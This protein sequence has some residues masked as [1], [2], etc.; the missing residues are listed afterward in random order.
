MHMQLGTVA[1]GAE[2]GVGQQ[3]ARRHQQER[4]VL[5]GMDPQREDTVSK[6]LV[7]KLWSL[8]RQKRR[9]AADVRKCHRCGGRAEP[10]KHGN[11]NPYR[12]VVSN[13]RL[14]VCKGCTKGFLAK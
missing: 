8:L 2:S 11:G 10:L 6:S 14:F 12:Q 5:A 13:K 3:R 9:P 4:G 7:S 1:A